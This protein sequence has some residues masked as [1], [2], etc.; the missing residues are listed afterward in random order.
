M[1]REIG[2][3]GRY[4]S[5]GALDSAFQQGGWSMCEGGYTLNTEVPLQCT[6]QQLVLVNLALD[7]P[8]A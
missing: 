1:R 6:P 2:E 5:S 7:L 4:E 3:T 8:G